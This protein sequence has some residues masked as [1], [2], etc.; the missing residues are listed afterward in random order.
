M[1]YITTNKDAIILP[2]TS[3]Q[4]AGSPG[5]DRIAKRSW[6][7]LKRVWFYDMR[8]PSTDI[9]QTTRMLNE[10]TARRIA[11]KSRRNA[12]NAGLHQIF[13]RRDHLPQLIIRECRET[14]ELQFLCYSPESWMKSVF[15][16]CNCKIELLWHYCP[17][18]VIK[19]LMHF[20]TQTK[21]QAM[22]ANFTTRH[23]S[24]W[25]QKTFQFLQGMIWA[26]W[27]RSR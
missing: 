10:N 18:F 20:Y 22:D 23:F 15:Q 27:T 2:L 8:K 11:S 4:W 26:S 16:R 5:F 9:K 12:K 24:S 6:L 19:T 1:D 3:A 14:N 7:F 25:W 13:A 17:K 21:T